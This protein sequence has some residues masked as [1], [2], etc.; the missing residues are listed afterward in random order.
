MPC[1]LSDWRY[2]KG[3]YCN[4]LCIRTA[5]PTHLSVK[6]VYRTG[7]AQYHFECAGDTAVLNLGIDLTG[8]IVHVY[9]SEQSINHG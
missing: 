8:A 9:T 6:S 1:K 3:L 5:T 4:G 2:D 7:V